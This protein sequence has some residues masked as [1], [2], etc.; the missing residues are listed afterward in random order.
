MRTILHPVILSLFIFSILTFSQPVGNWTFTEMSGTSLIDHSGNGNDGQ[1]D[2]ATWQNVSGMRTLSFDGVSN[3]VSIPHN[4]IFEF[5]TSNFT[6]EV[7]FKTDVVPTGSWSQIFSKHNTANW[8]DK[9]IELYVEGG[10]GLPVF[11]LSDGT[12]YFETAKGL[13]VVADGLF[14]TVRGIRENGQLKIYVDGDL[15]ATISASINPDN[16]NPI[17]IGR[18]SYNNGTGYFNGVISNI[19]LWNYAIPVTPV[20]NEQFNIPADYGISNNFPNPFN[21]STTINYSVPGA[22]NVNITVYDINGQVVKNLLNEFKNSG[23]YSLNWDGKNDSGSTVSSGTYFYQ[24][25]I[26]NFVQT[27]KMILLK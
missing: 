5:G 1:I 12:G 27:K 13:T 25:Q 18:S 23:S 20:E 14:H 8:H 6:L 10:T 19:S 16:T 17:N 9:D 15:E 26:G 21:P 3:Y 11:R 7:Q 24:I 4:S 2:G 22:S